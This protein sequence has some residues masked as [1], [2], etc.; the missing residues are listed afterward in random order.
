[1]GLRFNAVIEGTYQD[2]WGRSYY[3]TGKL[4][5]PQNVSVI[6]DGS[7]RYSFHGTTTDFNKVNES[8]CPSG[9]E[10]KVESLGMMY[11]QFSL[12]RPRAVI[13]RDGRVF[14]DKEITLEGY[15]EAVNEGNIIRTAGNLFNE[16]II[17]KVVKTRPISKIYSKATAFFKKITQ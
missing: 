12:E 7:Y 1:M 10:S 16:S 17:S 8:S 11:N 13:L 6:D 14:V 15:I 2:E 5:I 3:Q 9:I 4:D